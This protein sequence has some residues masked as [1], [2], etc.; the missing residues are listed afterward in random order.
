MAPRAG[1]RRFKLDVMTVLV[2]DENLMWSVKLKS[3]IEGLGHQA[4]VFSQMPEDYDG[5]VAIVNLGSRVFPPLDIL[6]KLQAKGIKT[7]AHAGH[8]EKPLL[9]VGADCGADLVVTNGELT[10]KLPEVLARLGQP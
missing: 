9:L 2:F 10:H 6:P 4:R 3:G 5:D 1:A 8:K 7:I